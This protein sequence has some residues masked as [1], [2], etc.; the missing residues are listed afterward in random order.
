MRTISFY[1]FRMTILMLMVL[2][3][4]LFLTSHG[5]WAANPLTEP[6]TLVA[7]KK[8]SGPYSKTVLLV[9]PAGDESHFGFIL[10]R[11]TPYLLKNLF[12]GHEP[13]KKVTDHVYFGGPAM[14]DTVFAIVKMPE[15]P[16]GAFRLMNDAWFVANTN[17]VD[18][19]IEERGN[20]ARYIVGFVV[21]KPGEL[22]EEMRRGAWYVEEPSVELIF[23]K[24]TT[25]LWEELEAK[26]S[27]RA[28][29]FST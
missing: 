12:P 10:N 6:A 24:D 23:K 25:G 5:V 4:A 22:A 3:L 21:W 26:H 15:K 7:N 20:D 27:A 11:E 13:S 29:R 19:V 17:A 9:V 8:L 14:S 2:A 18:R 16:D 28:R 1:V